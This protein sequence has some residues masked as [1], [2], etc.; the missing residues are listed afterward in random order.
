MAAVRMVS[1]KPRRQ[2]VQVCGLEQDL[3]CFPKLLLQLRG[4]EWKGQRVGQGYS[5]P[6]SAS[7]PKERVGGGA[8]RH[9]SLGL[10]DEPS[11]RGLRLLGEEISVVVGAGL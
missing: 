7:G 9:L 11:S 10:S 1:A 6:V 8:Y 3:I 4:S 2:Q 5:M